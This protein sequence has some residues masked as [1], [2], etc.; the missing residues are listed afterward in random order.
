MATQPDDTDLEFSSAERL[1][2]AARLCLL[3]DG[4]A[5]TSLKTIAA[6]AGVN[7]GLIHRYFGSKEALMIAV[8]EDMD[9]DLPPLGLADAKSDAA[10]IV[11]KIFKNQRVSIELLSLSYQMPALRQAFVR[12][13]RKTLRRYTE[14]TPKLGAKGALRLGS[15]LLGLAVYHAVDPKLPVQDVLERALDDL[16]LYS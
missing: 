2:E 11:E 15:T 16:G 5:H 6:R 1:V 10:F 14:Q 4:A 12:K 13:T 8:L 7:H 9:H 3:E